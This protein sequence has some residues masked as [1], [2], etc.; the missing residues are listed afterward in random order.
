MIRKFFLRKRENCGPIFKRDR[1]SGINQ[2]VIDPITC[3]QCLFSG[4]SA[5]FETKNSIPEKEKEKILRGKIVRPLSPITSD[6]SDTEIPAW[7]RYDLIAQTN[8]LLGKDQKTVAEQYLKASWA[9]RL[10]S[11]FFSTLDEKTNEKNGH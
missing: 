2:I 5:D 1:F 9:V 3:R 10:N 4:Y 8:Q 11:G 7:Q 6:S